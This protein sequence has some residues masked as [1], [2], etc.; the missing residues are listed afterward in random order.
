MP[1]EI[2]VVTVPPV[3]R[4]VADPSPTIMA[5]EAGATIKADP[6]LPVMVLTLSVF[7]MIDPVDGIT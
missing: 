1:F 7:A 6:A 5:P 4:V 2:V 3:A